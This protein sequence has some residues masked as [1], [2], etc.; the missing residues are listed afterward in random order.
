MNLST[1]GQHRFF[2]PA[3]GSALAVLVGLMLW[4]PI[5]DG[6]TNASY[7][8]LFHFCTFSATN[9]VVVILMDNEAYAE[10]GQNR[11]SAWDRSK[12]TKLFNKLADDGCLLVAPDIMFRRLD[13]AGVD[14]AMAESLRRLTNVVLAAAQSK[15]AHP[16]L[17][18]ARSTLP[19]DIFLNAARTNWGVAWLDPAPDKVVR[20]HW[21]FSS[22]GPYPSLPWTAAKLSGA[23]LNETPSEKWIRYYDFNKTWVSL[24]YHVALVQNPGY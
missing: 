4:T 5:G 12:H 9:Q 18:S 23:Q 11:E 20:H 13:D 24:S 21:P 7:D 16:G 22:P 10:L 1:I 6:W 14:N 15:L 17:D 8:C 2:R 3:A 19:L